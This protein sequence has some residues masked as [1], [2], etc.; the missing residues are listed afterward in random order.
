MPLVEVKKTIRSEIENSLMYYG[1]TLTRLSE[2]SGINPGHLSSILRGNPPRPISIRQLDAITKAF[3]YPKDWFYELYVDECF[4]T[5]KASRPR[6]EAFLVRC[7]EI[8]KHECIDKTISLLM[9]NPKQNAIL[10]SIAERLFLD[11]KW[12]E[13]IPFYK[14]VIENEKDSHSERFA[15]SQYRLFR[16]LLGVDAEENLKAVIQFDPYRKRLPED[17]QLDAL[18]QLA[19]TC[20]TLQ[21]WKETEQYADELRV[22]ATAT[23]EDELRKLRTNKVSE[24]LNTERHLVVYYAMGHLF[25]GVALEMQGLYEQAKPYVQVYADLGWFE[26]L[27]EV[28]RQEVEKFKVGA[29]ANF[30]ALEVLT[31]NTTIITE[32]A[33]YLSRLPNNELLA[34]LVSIMQ[35]AN[36]Y[37]VCVDELLQRFCDRIDQFNIFTDA[38]NVD[39]HYQFRYQKAIYEFRKQRMENGIDETLESLSLLH[40]MNRHYHFIRCISLFEKYRAYASE[41]HI[42]KYQTIVTGEVYV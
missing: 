10:F 39:R 2:L 37:N 42:K 36:T 11:K 32:Y 28:G 33:D 3:G 40:L 15:I 18:L 20:F 19:R 4:I 13:S 21:R 1:Y 29:R 38:I 41:Q 6:V 23:Y 8:G 27:D 25:K 7:A 31:G 35:T 12:K 22:L 9:E 5:G 16:A 24:P 14:S 30:Y 34:G 17:Y 26:L